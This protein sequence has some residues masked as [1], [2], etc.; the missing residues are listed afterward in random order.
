MKKLRHFDPESRKRDKASGEQ[1]RDAKSICF[2]LDYE[3]V[4]LCSL[5]KC[6]GCLKFW[7]LWP[8]SYMELNYIKLKITLAKSR[9][10]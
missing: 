7:K 1:K 10:E 4:K 8:S 3:V 2:I 6:A 9:S 5:T